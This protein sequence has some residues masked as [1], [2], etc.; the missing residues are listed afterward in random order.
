MVTAGIGGGGEEAEGG[1]LRNGYMLDSL[2]PMRNMFLA[3]SKCLR[4][5]FLKGR[6][7]SRSRGGSR[8]GCSGRRRGLPP[9]SFRAGGDIPHLGFAKQGSAL[10]R[11]CG[12]GNVLR[13]NTPLGRVQNIICIKKAIS[14]KSQI[15]KK[16]GNTKAEI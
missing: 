1:V 13:L 16:S 8:S 3:R 15:K 7:F 6:P 14:N 9:R 2:R 11:H 10:A 5:P 4:P 12:K